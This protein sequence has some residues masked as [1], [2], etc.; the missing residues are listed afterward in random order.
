MD[1]PISVT[2]VHRAPR[3]ATYSIEQLFEVIREAMPADIQTTVIRAPSPRATPGAMF[4]NARAC[5]KAD[6]KIAHIVGDV[7]YLALACPPQRTIVTVHDLGMLTAPQSIFAR[8]AKRFLWFTAPLRHARLVTVISEAT[9][10][11]LLDT[12]NIDPGKVRII[13]NCVAPQFRPR[14]APPRN[15][16]FRLLHIGSTPNKNLRRVALACRGLNVTLRI[17]GRLRP[18]Q[19]Q[20]LEEAGVCFSCVSDL[21]LREMVAEYH[22]ADA[23]V[24]PSL[25]EGFGM[26]IIE[27]QACGVPVITSD[28]EPMR[29]VTG[30]YALLVNPYSVEHIR[31]GI[32]RLMSQPRLREHLSKAGVKHAAAFR[33]T[34]VAE[35]YAELYRE[36]ARCD[37]C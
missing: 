19:E 17:V 8:G 27:A 25:L 10:N 31:W 30:G 14:V 5:V 37:R 13:P 26:P 7:H 4:Q 34:E 36:V 22:Q 35:Q 29:T 2:L 21:S 15:S 16:K 18:S 32:V 11:A 9:R 6:P 33:A 23:V 20:I 12:V 3:P 24:F 1:P 28:L